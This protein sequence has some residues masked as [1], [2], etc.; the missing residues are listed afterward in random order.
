MF[1]PPRGP[2]ADRDAAEVTASPFPHRDRLLLAT[3]TDENAPLNVAAPSEASTDPKA[4]DARYS[5]YQKISQHEH[6]LL[7][8][9][10]Y[11]GS[12]ELVTEEMWVFDQEASTIV[13]RTITYVPA[14]L[15]IFDEILVNAA[16]NKQRDP[17]QDKIK[18]VIDKENN[19]ISVENNGSG[20]PVVHHPEHDMYV[21]TMIFGHLLTG[22]NFDDDE[23]KTTGGRNGYGA[24]LANIFSTRFV[25]ETV[26][27]SE[28]KHFRQVFSNNMLDREEP[29]IRNSKSKEFTKIEF[30]PDLQRFHMDSMSQDVYQ[31][32]CRRVYD[33]AACSTMY[34]GKKLQVFLNG[35]K[36]G[37][38][39]FSDYVA[40]H[41]GLEAPVAF[42]KIGD[43]WE[44][45]VS[46]SDGQ[47]RQLSYV[48]A[49]STTKGGHHVNAIV[50]QVVDR[51][52][53]SIKKKNKGQE[54]KPHTIKTHLAVY[55]NCLIE[56]P[57]FDSQTKEMLTTRKNAFGSSPNLSEKFLKKVEKSE[58]VQH[59]LSYAAFKQQKELNRK[60]G[61][62]RAKLTGIPK[63][64][65]ANFAGTAK[66]KDCTLIL[67]E[68]DSAK[69]LAVAGLAVVGRD[70]YGVFPLKGKPLNVRDASHK[71]IMGNEEMSSIVRILG[72]KF[73][74]EYTEENIKTLRYGHLMIMADQD[75]DGSH[76]KGLIINFIHFFWPSLLRVPGFLQQFIT[77]IV[78]VKARGVEQSFFSMPAFNTW[79]SENANVTGVDIKYY[80][81]LGTS[82]PK[83][84]KE[85][86]S[87]LAT[88]QLRFATI[89]DEDAAGASQ[90]SDL[91]DMAFKKNRVE[92]RKNW[93]LSCDQEVGADYSQG[94][95][96]YADFVNHELVLFSIADCERS[97][98]NMID[99][100]KT[101]QRKVLWSC[102]K[103]SLKKD[104]K[105]AQLVGYVSEQSAYHHGEA[106]LASTIV[107]LAQNFVGSNNV[108][109]LVPSGQ[110]GTRA[111]GGKDAASPRYIFTRLEDI[112]RK[113][114]HPDDDALLDYCE[115]DGKSIE[116]RFYVPVLP[117]VL[118]NGADGIGTGWSASVPN[119][120][121][122]EVIE[123]LRRK[124]SGEDFVN[125]APS[126]RGFNGTL[127][128]KTG[129]DAGNYRMLGV[130]EKLSETEIRISELPI[131][132]WTQ[133]YKLFLES[134][135]IE[136]DAKGF[137]QD[138]KENHTDTHVNFTVRIPAEK[139]SEIEASAGGLQKKL[140]LE[141]SVSTSNM[142]LFNKDGLIQ[143]YNTVV[144][145]LEEFYELRL[146]MYSKRKAHLEGKLEDEWSKLDNKVRFVLAVIE[147]DFVVSNRPRKQ[148]LED[149]RDRGFRAF[150]PKASKAAAADDADGA[151]AEEDVADDAELAKGYDYLLGMK[152]WS[153][154]M[155][156]V[157]SLR[158][159]RDEK[160]AEL[161]TLRNTT[162]EQL[163]LHD[164]DEV[165]AAFE[166]MEA[167]M[168]R[169]EEET[170]RQQER[171]Q[172][173]K[174]TTKRKPRAKKA[175]VKKEAPA[176]KPVVVDVSSAEEKPQ[177][178]DGDDSDV[179]LLSLTERLA[180]KATT[181]SGPQRKAPRAN[182]TTPTW[183]AE[184]GA[185]AGDSLGM[186]DAEDDAAAKKPAV[187]R[188]APAKKAA[189]AT[190][191]KP[192]KKAVDSD[193]DD[194]VD[195]KLSKLELADEEDEE[196]DEVAAPAAP[197]RGGRAAAAR[198]K[199]RMAAAVESD[200]SEEEDD[201][202]DFEES[203]FDDDESDYDE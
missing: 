19:M 117:M 124:L 92:D 15:K 54:V 67:T 87:D 162:A 157:E 9:D 131:R 151:D 3:M 182:G 50:D 122:V 164:L 75:H 196:N 94:E 77:P 30:S 104:V 201:E 59:I 113:I 128:E 98:P 21:P 193:S 102:F 147:G 82:T 58:V 41:D 55:V 187:K 178:A 203:D 130:H 74:T 38:K 106:S 150:L 48:N 144:D 129:R 76:I 114:F 135:L 49:I 145:I 97:I 175:A 33:I 18:V 47:P 52:Q 73:Q 26:D 153:L 27:A 14:L 194:A 127:V 186:L 139:L 143:K 45:G 191:R 190:V 68:G 159:Q 44:V 86:F 142:H 137:V 200:E 70:Y 20:I 28:G 65:D 32:L 4:G 101:S 40:M 78:K 69:A 160:A 80:K 108:N 22:S 105:V 136:K 95:V 6:V 149:L 155:E 37:L 171:K 177:A 184:D 17:T 161:E 96:R 57:A 183:R 140:K 154:T 84:A 172:A 66:S 119:Y 176:A 158:R 89:K 60:G 107:G 99:G 81:G 115:D 2:P 165:Q 31:L 46:F 185:P 118:V 156:K 25:V 56:N 10:T 103:R 61:S 43:R 197:R 79:R 111:L 53:K 51:L 24:K 180:I 42:E 62:K 83:E 90:D 173:A 195:I 166:D 88:H 110:F 7:R 168:R 199:S 34:S 169:E 123:N 141:G 93:I 112:T 134:S 202:S 126:Y 11:V 12:T 198:S 29:V 170:M 179:E 146:E 181:G 120:S 13:K 188:R 35:E 192:A 91:I 71:Q 8:P 36:I 133:D 174:K 121:V 132:K 125:M 189:K 148:L 85:Y 109:L 16:D 167:T 100:F 138:F 39:G 5:K 1:L 23:R 72:L 64:D 63:L 152:I 163:W 116:P